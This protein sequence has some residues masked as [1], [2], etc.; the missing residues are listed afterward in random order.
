MQWVCE[1]CGYV[2]DD[3]DRP[4]SCP[5]CGTPGAKFS[6][7][8]DDDHMLEGHSDDKGVDHFDKDL[9]ADYEDE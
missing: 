2:H 7:R 8:F 5:V 3:E 1:F 9:Y 4:H 6:E